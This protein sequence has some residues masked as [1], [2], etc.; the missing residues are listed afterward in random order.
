MENAI[1]ASTTNLGFTETEQLLAQ[2][3]L[4][5]KSKPNKHI[6]VKASVLYKLKKVVL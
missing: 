6:F 5:R 1:T 3:Q 4:N 2:L